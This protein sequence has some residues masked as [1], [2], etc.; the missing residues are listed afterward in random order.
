M[1]DEQQLMV[2]EGTT[3]YG[4][5]KDTPFPLQISFYFYNLTNP[6]EFAEGETPIL[7]ERGPY[8]YK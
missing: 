2:R 8:I 1:F 4:I 3:A 5:W 6:V 7:E